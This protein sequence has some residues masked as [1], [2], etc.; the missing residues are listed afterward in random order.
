MS[1]DLACI[2]YADQDRE[3]LIEDL[4]HIFKQDF[5]YPNFNI[6]QNEVEVLPNLDFDSRKRKQFPDGFLH[7]QQLVEI[8][9][10]ESQ[11]QSLDNQIQLVSMILNGLWSRRVPAIAAC[12]YE[13]HLPNNG[14]YKSTQVPF[15]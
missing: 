9:P 8:F 7:F 10:D 4:Q 12:D 1:I 14:G 15:P 13:D 11:N 5:H 6:L 3:K 2:I